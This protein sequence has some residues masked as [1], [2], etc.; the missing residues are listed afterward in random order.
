LG[1]A[2]GGDKGEGDVAGDELDDK[3]VVIFRDV[4]VKTK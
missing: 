3:T 4:F 2:D 1:F